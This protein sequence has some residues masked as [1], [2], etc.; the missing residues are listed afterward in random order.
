MQ[1]GE[2]KHRVEIQTPSE[3]GSNNSLRDKTTWTTSITRWA[4]VVEKSS[5]ET[6]K[7]NQTVGTT[8][9]Q[10]VF[11]LL[12]LKLDYRLRHGEKLLYIS[13]I[14]SDDNWTTCLCTEREV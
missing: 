8:V 6:S 9:Y 1:I 4:S 2:L 14:V 11:R 3:T 5:S 12:D 10:V 13:S 7:E